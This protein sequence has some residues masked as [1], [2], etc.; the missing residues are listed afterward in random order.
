MICPNCKSEIEDNCVVCN[1]CGE[2]IAPKPAVPPELIGQKYRM[3]S[4][5]MT[6][7]AIG[8]GRVR[9]GITFE[10]EKMVF[11]IFP[12]KFKTMDE[13]YYNNIASIS[14]EKKMTLFAILECITII[15]I[16][17]SLIFGINT[18]MTVKTKDGRQIVLYENM[19]R[20]AQDFIKIIEKIIELNK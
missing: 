20:N 17:F 19:S 4:A 10:E 6:T 11:D 14:F 3:S 5:R 13:L 8:N 18:I 1:V 9:Q 7:F 2:N 12:K 15:C 16:P